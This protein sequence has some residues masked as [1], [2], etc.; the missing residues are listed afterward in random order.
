MAELETDA[1]VAEEEAPKH[2]LPGAKRREYEVA[3]KLLTIR[4]HR[5]NFALN[6]HLNTRGE[7]MDFTHYPHIRELY[8]SVARIIVLQGSVQSFKSE[9]AVIDQLACAFSGLSVFFVLPKYEMRTTYVQNRINRPCETITEYKRIVGESFF[10]SV[11]IKNFGK[12]VIKYVGSNVLADFKEFPADCIFVEEVDECDQENVEYALDRLRA[13]KYQFRRYLGNPKLENKGINAFFKKSDQREW[14]VPCLDC[15]NFHELDW[16]TVVVR[17]LTDSEGNVVDYV[18][19]DESWEPGCRRDVKCICPDCGGELERASVRGVWIAKDPDCP[20]EG[21]HI[22]M[23]CSPINAVAEM[24][25]KFRDAITDPALMQV[26]FNSYLGQ[27]YNAVGNKVTTSLLDKAVE[28]GYNLVIRDNCAH[29]EGDKHEGVCSMGVDIGGVFDVRISALEPRGVRKLVY[30]GKLKELDEIHDLIERYNVEYCVVDSMPEITLVQ[31][32]QETAPCG[33]WLCR[34]RGEGADRRKNYDVKDHIINVD[35]T[36]C[37]D[38]SFAALRRGKLI[39]PENYNSILGGQWTEEMC[40]PVRRVVEDTKG[41]PKFEW[42]KCKDHQRHA[43]SYD[44][45]AQQIILET[46]ISDIWVG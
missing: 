37:L 11:A 7:K 36:E 25:Q 19:R 12:G 28:E 42:S 22:S 40:G 13:S 3:E 6:H 20:V 15:G 4:N 23:L 8:N 27:P 10:D 1:E 2:M 14:N 18:L 30:V 35:R 33:V 16:F 32:F 39:I 17:D 26:F 46:E 29:I 24:W 41:N 38:R 9:W 21:Y 44:L 5:Q 34:Y 31:D 45:L 43:D